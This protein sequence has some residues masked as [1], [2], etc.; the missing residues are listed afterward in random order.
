[1]C[2]WPSCRH[3]FHA[4]GHRA[5]FILCSGRRS[6]Q[7]LTWDAGNTLAIPCNPTHSR[8]AAEAPGTQQVTGIRQTIGM[9]LLFAIQTPVVASAFGIVL[10]EYSSRVDAQSQLSRMQQYKRSQ[11]IDILVSTDEAPPSRIWTDLAAQIAQD[12]AEVDQIYWLPIVSLGLLVWLAG[13]FGR[14]ISRDITADLT[15]IGS[16]IRH[17]T[18]TGDGQ[19]RLGS[20]GFRETSRIVAAFEDAVHNFDDQ[21]VRMTQAAKKR[22]IAEQQKSTFLTHISH[23]LKSPLNSILGFSELMLAGIDDPSTSDNVG[24]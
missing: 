9:R 10:V 1:M 23:E 4:A 20:V 2:G 5:L 18:M 7:L 16:G 12:A 17:L 8:N 15:A 21:H 24:R 3:A 19:A 14:W 6:G 11:L 13:V 22:R